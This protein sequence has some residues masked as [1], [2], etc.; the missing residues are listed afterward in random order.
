MPWQVVGYRAGDEA[1]E[2]LE[3]R[4]ES[5]DCFP[6]SLVGVYIFRI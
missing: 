2:D 5:E 3:K 4:R 1:G 6:V